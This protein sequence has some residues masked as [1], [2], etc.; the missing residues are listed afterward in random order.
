ME[1]R[2]VEPL[3]EMS[4]PTA[5]LSAGFFCAQFRVQFSIEVTVNTFG[6]FVLF[7]AERM[8]IGGLEHIVR[9]MPHASHRIL[10][11]DAQQ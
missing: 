1:P 6:V 11:R 5:A 10:I 8:L 4:I 9:A 7:R 2:G 3:E